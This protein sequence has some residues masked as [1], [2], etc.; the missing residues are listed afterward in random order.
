M[1][2]R[3][4]ELGHVATSGEEEEVN[5]SKGYVAHSPVLD[6]VGAQ[7]YSGA[8]SIR[9]SLGETAAD[10]PQ[11]WDPPLGRASLARA[12]NAPSDGC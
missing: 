2:C 8:R 9:S 11:A 12:Q 5:K 7:G 10:V 3:F 4:S 6:H 1:R